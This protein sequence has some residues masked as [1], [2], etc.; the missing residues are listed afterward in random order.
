MTVSFPSEH[1]VPFLYLSSP[2]TQFTS[3]FSDLCWRCN[4]VC[5][6]VFPQ[7]GSKLA[8]V[9]HSRS[10]LFI[11]APFSGGLV[12]VVLWV[13][14][15]LLF[16]NSGPVYSHSLTT[17]VWWPWLF[18]SSISKEET[19]HM[20]LFSLLILGYLSGWCCDWHPQRLDT[21]CENIIL[22]EGIA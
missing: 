22:I 10:T 9:L 16:G 3:H 19:Q 1:F 5:M 12:V 20:D 13:F 4:H 6:V 8:H 11:S 15:F 7:A 18:P 14:K 17:V 2:T 21:C